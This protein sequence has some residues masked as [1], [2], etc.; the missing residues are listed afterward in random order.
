MG[1]YVDVSIFYGAKIKVSIESENEDNDDNNEYE[2]PL[3]RK[4]HRISKNL[5]LTPDLEFVCEYHGYECEYVLIGVK[6]EKMVDTKSGHNQRIFNNLSLS[7]LVRI[8][9]ETKAKYENDIRTMVNTLFPEVPEY[10]LQLIV[11]SDIE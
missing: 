6:V 9:Q 4:F 7:S 5:S 8:E 11:V 3:E 2:C 1:L 10:D